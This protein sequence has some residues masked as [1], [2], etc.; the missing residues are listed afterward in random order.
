MDRSAVAYR[1]GRPLVFGEVLF[2]TF[3]DGAEVLGGASFNVAW[4]LQGLGLNPL[5]I[6]RIGDDA[7]GQRVLEAMRAWGMD[8]RGVQIDGERSTGRVDVQLDHGQ[9][10]YTVLPDRAY[11]FIERDVALAALSGKTLSLLYHGSLI[12][13]SSVSRALLQTL[14]SL[15]HLP[16]VVDV[17]LRA[18]WWN[19]ELVDTLLRAARWVQLNET[20][21][22]EVTE[23]AA[24]PKQKIEAAARALCE[25]YDLEF[26]IL[27]QGAQGAY[28]ISPTT[29]RYGAAKQID[30][31]VDT[32]GAGDAFSAVT[33][34]GLTQGWPLSLVLKRALEFA[35][36][37][38]HLRGPISQDRELYTRYLAR[39]RA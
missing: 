25:R 31:L 28:F 32:V 14:R 19:C 27:T 20:E 29:T 36:T 34:L 22:A 38:C 21:L 7:Q 35:A 8:W 15:P 17:N 5:F 18:P 11:D 6:T 30:D 26:L 4:H 23:C 9:P 2:D 24:L 12:A 39:W 13:R 16:A 37:V 10:T 1:Q 3:P 33:I